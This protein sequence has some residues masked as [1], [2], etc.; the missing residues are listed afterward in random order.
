MV[1]AY[2]LVAPVFAVTPVV[3]VVPVVRPVAVAV[4]YV[5]P[6]W[7]CYKNQSRFLLGLPLPLICGIFT[8]SITCGS[9]AKL[10]DEA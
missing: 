8:I 5:A 10:E 4:P 6:R 9:T 2:G 1:Y 3:P 7:V